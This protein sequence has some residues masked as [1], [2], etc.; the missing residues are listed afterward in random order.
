ME[1]E[2]A[3]SVNL[4][5]IGLANVIWKIASDQQCKM[6]QYLLFCQFLHYLK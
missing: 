3:V 6:G 5:N 2:K 1:L 4:G